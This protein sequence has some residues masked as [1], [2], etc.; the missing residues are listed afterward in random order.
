M[1]KVLFFLFFHLSVVIIAQESLQ[2]NEREYFHLPGLDV[3][4]FSDYYPEGH[5]SGLTIIQ[6]GNRVA[7]NGDLRLEPSPGQWSPVP[8][9]GE[10]VVDRENQQIS[11]TLWFPD[12][13]KNRRGFNPVIYPDLRFTYQVHVAP[14]EGNSFRVWVDLEEPLPDEWAGKVGF[15]LE[16]FPGDLFGKSFLMD[17]QTGIFP[18]QPVGPMTSF[19]GEP[20]TAP[21]GRGTALV[22]AP[23]EELQRMKIVSESRPLE[24]WDGRSNHNNGWFIVR[25]TIPAGATTAAVDW[26][27]TPNTVPGWRYAPVIQVSQLGYHPLQKKVAVVELDPDE[28]PES[29]F[30]LYRLEEKGR[31]LVKETETSRWGEFLR[32]QYLTLDFTEIEQEGLYQ[33]GY[34]NQISR[35]FRIA[36]DVFGNAAWQ[37]TLDYYLPVQMCHMR[38]NEKYRV[39]HDLCHMDDARMA[40][41]VP[42]HFDGYRQG[43]ENYTS[44]ESG[45]AVPGLNS[46]GW[47]DAGDYD[48]RVESQAG[49]VWLLA[50]MTEEFGLSH[51]ATMIDHQNHLVEIH[52]PDGVPDAIQQIEHGLATILGGYRSLGRLYRGIICP[53]KRQYVMLGDASAMTDNVAGN[54]DD[55]WVFTEDNPG[56]ELRVIP[57]LAAS[58]RVL[59][60]YNP[61][62]AGESLQAAI[63]L[64]ESASG[65]QGHTGSKVL[66]LSELILATGDQE[67]MDTMLS[68]REQ[69]V[70]HIDDCGWALGHV[71]KEIEDARFRREITG[72]IEEYLA[73]LRKQQAADSP[74][75]VP[76]QPNIWGAGWSI[77]RF[78][79]EQYFVHKGWPELAGTD[80]FENSLHFVLGVHPGS[81]NASFASGVGSR[82]IKVAYGVNRA[83]WSFIPGGVVSGTALIRPDLPE[84]KTWPFLWQQTEYVMGGGATNYMFL[85]LAV[86]HLYNP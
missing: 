75:G 37:P 67:Y 35:P 15:N 43:E 13:S 41:H 1:K 9:G 17:E 12:S 59:K 66:A 4:F 24:L 31:T 49:T 84:L 81:N 68:M 22:I 72:A 50:L 58:S 25:S 10:R 16:L 38:V 7:A 20:L 39:W 34:G 63:A 54:S 73:D 2:L 85:V 65:V 53:E 78:G 86:N 23:G 70:R 32:Y 29:S 77:Q 76:Y 80:F 48:L 6:H 61:E 19:E 74:Y 69:I 5:Q 21:L 40:P 52:Q 44:F 51:D 28:N 57:A 82:S 11:Q 42:Y 14:S 33:V 71:L 83:D 45:D 47:H 60:P 56:R 46:G 3:T 55:R 36:G 26:T 79:V 64:W 62:L 8:K 27:I 18:D 30:R